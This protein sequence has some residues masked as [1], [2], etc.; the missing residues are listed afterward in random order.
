MACVVMSQKIE[1]QTVECASE[2]LSAL[3]RRNDIWRGHSHSFVEQEVV[4]SGHENLNKALLHK[5]WPKSCLIE[6]NQTNYAATWLLFISVLKRMSER[7]LVALI[8]PPA[9]PYA[10][11]LIQQG[12]D[13][14]SVLIARPA[15]KND[16]VASFVDLA[17]SRV[18]SMLMAWQPQQRLTY[19]E[20][21]KCQLATLEHQGLTFLFRHDTALQQSSPA[22]L[23]I[24][25]TVHARYLNL[26]FIKQ[27]GKLPGEVVQLAFP[28]HWFG[29][30]SYKD[31]DL[32]IDQ[33]LHQQAQAT[34]WLN[35]APSRLVSLRR[36]RQ[37]NKIKKA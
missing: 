36:Y 29:L 18:C 15:D 23:R 26:E 31:L 5:G 37:N 30:E 24:R 13:L 22:A 3:L 17:K 16:F 2:A 20:L 11:S 6:C 7:G 33:P 8:N 32:H 28:D 35:Q 4:D 27:K 34:P 9:D 25:L 14:D 12:V 10:V 1:T 19:A 21:R